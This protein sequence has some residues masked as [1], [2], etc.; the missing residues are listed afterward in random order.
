MMVF[1]TEKNSPKFETSPNQAGNFTQT[2]PNRD[3]ST[4]NFLPESGNTSRRSSIN[5]I[6]NGMLF[7]EDES[8][9]SKPSTVKNQESTILDIPGR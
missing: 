7:K 4:K 8:M 6:D 1:K 9:V 5:S 2:R 3:K